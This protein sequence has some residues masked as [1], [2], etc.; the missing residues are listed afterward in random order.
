MNAVAA[1]V[2]E[3]VAPAAQASPDGSA[4]SPVTAVLGSDP[5]GPTMVHAVPSQCAARVACLA[6]L[7]M[8]VFGLT[9]GT[10]VQVGVA[11]MAVPA[12]RVSEAPAASAAGMSRCRMLVP[13]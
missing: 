5:V 3:K 7:I 12:S 8:F 13:P 9:L 1:P 2:A 6:K 11:A 10:T 4:D